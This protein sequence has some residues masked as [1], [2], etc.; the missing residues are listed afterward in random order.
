MLEPGKRSLVIGI[1]GF[2]NLSGIVGAQLFRAEYAPRY[3]T[4]F[5]V[6][7]ALIILS[8][9]GYLSYRGALK[10]VNRWRRDKIEGWSREMLERERVGGERYADRKWTFVYGL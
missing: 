7:L 5:Y 1:N 8:M 9:G 4:P 2:G 6:T 3:L 10:Q